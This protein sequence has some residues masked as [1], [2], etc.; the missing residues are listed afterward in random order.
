MADLVGGTE[1]RKATF[2]VHKISMASIRRAGG[3][4]TVGGLIW[5]KIGVTHAGWGISAQYARDGA[6]V[7]VSLP[8]AA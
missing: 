5:K 6:Y 3:V 2:P 7:R 8:D 4:K 1:E